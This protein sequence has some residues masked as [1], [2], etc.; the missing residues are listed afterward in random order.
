MAGA[1]AQIE[2]EKSIQVRGEKRE[3]K[4]DEANVSLL[5]SNDGKC[6]F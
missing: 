4:M 3:L 6:H 5:I 1:E 2:Y